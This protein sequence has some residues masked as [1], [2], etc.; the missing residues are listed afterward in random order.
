[1]IAGEEDTGS[2]FEVFCCIAQRT[3]DAIAVLKR[4]TVDAFN[5]VNSTVNIFNSN[6][7]E[8]FCKMF[9]AVI[10]PQQR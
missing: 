2:Q 6:I 8:D 10:F 9:H 3:D 1:M 5:I 7:P 4:T